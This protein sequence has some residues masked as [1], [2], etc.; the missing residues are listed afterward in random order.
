MVRRAAYP[1]D[2]DIRKLP[3]VGATLNPRAVACVMLRRGAMM[4]VPV[5]RSDLQDCDGLRLRN[6]ILQPGASPQL[7]D[8]LACGRRSR[9][10]RDPMQAR[11]AG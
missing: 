1:D 9:V 2:R 10:G 8:V 6:S 11:R 4:R 5:V 7:R 3:P